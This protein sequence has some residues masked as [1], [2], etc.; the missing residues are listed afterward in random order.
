AN[1]KGITIS[2][3]GSGI[4]WKDDPPSISG[5]YGVPKGA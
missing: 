1:R 3:G 4:C 2:G 5:A